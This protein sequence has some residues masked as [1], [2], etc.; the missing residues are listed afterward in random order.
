MQIFLKLGQTQLDSKSEY[1]NDVT[2]LNPSNVPPVVHN[3]VVGVVVANAR[4]TL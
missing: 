1:L 4:T 2:V 3:P